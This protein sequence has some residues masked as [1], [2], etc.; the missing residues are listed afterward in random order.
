MKYTPFSKEPLLLVMFKWSFHMKALGNVSNKLSTQQYLIISQINM[1]QRNR[2]LYP[3]V[4]CNPVSRFMKMFHFA[5]IPAFW[6]LICCPY[7]GNHSIFRIY[8]VHTKQ[9]YKRIAE[10]ILCYWMHFQNFLCLWE[11][12][13]ITGALCVRENVENI[14]NTVPLFVTL[15]Y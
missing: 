10:T 6:N 11:L 14:L 1:Q 4:V 9:S 2:N 12:Q 5:L 7:F 13:K 8:W 3:Y 15:C